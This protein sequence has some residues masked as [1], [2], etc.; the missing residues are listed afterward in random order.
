MTIADRR[1]ACAKL[2]GLYGHAISA[3]TAEAR[4]LLHLFMVYLSTGPTAAE[5]ALQGLLEAYTDYH[6]QIII[7]RIEGNGGSSKRSAG[8]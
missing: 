3:D 7:E 4:A 8:S 6:G 2:A 5:C 1:R